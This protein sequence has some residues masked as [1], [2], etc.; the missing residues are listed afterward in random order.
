MESIAAIFD[1]ITKENRRFMVLIPLTARPIEEVLSNF[2]SKFNA[3]GDIVVDMR[4][5]HDDNLKDIAAINQFEDWVG[6]VKGV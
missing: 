6:K 2:N 3:E 1:L 4:M 5:I